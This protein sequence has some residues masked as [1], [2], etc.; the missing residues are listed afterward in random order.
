M[1]CWE[2]RKSYEGREAR[3]LFFF[4]SGSVAAGESIGMELH[5]VSSPHPRSWKSNVKGPTLVIDR[6]VRLEE[7]VCRC[8]GWFGR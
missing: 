8:Q 1:N 2:G 4:S 7:G 6:E 5:A 3:F